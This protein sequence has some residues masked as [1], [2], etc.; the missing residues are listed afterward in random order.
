MIVALSSVALASTR[1]LAR[2]ETRGPFILHE[3]VITA[4]DRALID[5]QMRDF[6]W[7]CWHQHR[8]C[9]LITLAFSME[10]LPTRTT[11]FIEPDEKGIWRVVI[12][13]SATV[14]G[15]KP[16]TDEHYTEDFTTIATLESVN[17]PDGKKHIR[18]ISNG[19]TLLD[20]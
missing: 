20:L 4:D 18:V 12:E 11:Y 2:Y 16:G 13:T 9:R 6:L 1:D 19:K 7:S 15:V 10:G 14:P 8:R 5:A 3:R 17:G